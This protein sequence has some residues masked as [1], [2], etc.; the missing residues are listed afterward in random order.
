ME[1]DVNDPL[2]GDCVYIL[3]HFTRIRGNKNDTLALTYRN[4]IRIFKIARPK[5]ETAVARRPHRSKRLL[6]FVPACVD[7][8]AH[9]VPSWSRKSL[10]KQ[11]NRRS[12]RAYDAALF[13][14]QKV[15]AENKH[16]SLRWAG[17]LDI[18]IA[19]VYAH[20]RFDQGVSSPAFGSTAS[21]LA[22]KKCGVYLTSTAS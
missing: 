10:T 19:P 21:H 8:V 5:D 15:H 17:L 18:R 6:V 20:R 4:L 13:S 1:Y 12:T 7:V 16:R 11:T 3:Y 14:R 22:R 2:H 9:T